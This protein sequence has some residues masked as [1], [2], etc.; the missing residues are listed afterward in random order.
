M[1]DSSAPTQQSA[2]N[3]M[4]TAYHLK[5]ELRNLKPAIAREVLVAPGTKLSKLHDIIQAAMGWHNEHL[6]GFAQLVGNESYYRAPP[7]RRFEPAGGE[8][9]GF[10]EPANDETR[11][12]VSDVLTAPRQKL[13]YCY[14]F[15]DDWEHTVTLKAIINTDEVLPMLV[16]AQNACP[17]ENCGGP[18]GFIDLAHAWYEADHEMHEYARDVLGEHEPGWFDFEALERAVVRLRPRAK[19]KS[20]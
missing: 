16:K 20:V 2:I 1:G 5:I 7:E 13:A 6:H 4:H 17:P 12:K 19:M 9:D 8:L 18:P 15:G 14:D 10:G 11:V 3:P